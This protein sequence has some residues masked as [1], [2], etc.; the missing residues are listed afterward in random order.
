MCSVT[1]TTKS[2]CVK[3]NTTQSISD[4][5][6][7]LFIEHSQKGTNAVTGAVVYQ[8][9]KVYILVPKRY[10]SVIIFCTKFNRRLDAHLWCY[11]ENF[12]NFYLK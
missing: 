11:C 9:F 2:S 10:K 7:H 3:T 6:R 4:Q 8:Y 12:H 5:T 1:I